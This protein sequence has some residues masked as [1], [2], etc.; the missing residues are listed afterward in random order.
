MTKGIEDIGRPHGHDLSDEQLL[1]VANEI[2]ARPALWSHRIAHDPAHRTYEQLLRD[3]HR[4]HGDERVDLGDA[5][6]ARPALDSA[7][8]RH[9]GF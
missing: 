2:A 3:E 1:S 6:H 5:E 9:R 8:R 7:L 4:Y